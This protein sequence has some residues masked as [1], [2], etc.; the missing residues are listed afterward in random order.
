MHRS[1][2]G[3]PRVPNSLGVSVARVAAERLSHATPPD[4]SSEA[5]SAMPVLIDDDLIDDRHA[6]GSSPSWATWNGVGGCGA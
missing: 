3:D 6:P 2:C 4:Q 1:P 5:A